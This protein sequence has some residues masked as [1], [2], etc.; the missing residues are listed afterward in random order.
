[1]IKTFFVPDNEDNTSPVFGQFEENRQIVLDRLRLINPEYSDLNSQDVLIPSLI[2]AYTDENASTVALTPFPV[3]PGVNWRVDYKGL[4]RIPSIKE[5]FQSFNISHSYSSS[6]TVT[7]YTNSLLYQDDLT[8]NNDIEDYPYAFT[9]NDNGDLVPVYV[10]NQVVVSERFSPLLGISVRTRSRMTAQFEIKRERNIALNL[11]NAQ[12]T[13]TNNKDYV[14]TIGFTKADMRVPFRV[15]GRTVSLENDLTFRLDFN[16]KDA[17]II[18]RKI[19]ETNTITNG[20]ISYQLRPNVSYVLNQRL[21]MKFYFE[22]SI[23]QPRVS[24]SFRRSTTAFGVQ[25]RFS[26]AQ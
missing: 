26:L 19:E 11:S 7:N 24:N 14:F 13:E 4:T 21:N 20:N 18:Q 9:L 22:R 2:A 1:M 23:N 17:K 5:V 25:V 12:V 16:V 8:L 15:Q 3:R 10:I 6:Y